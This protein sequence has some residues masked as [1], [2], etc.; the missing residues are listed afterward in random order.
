MRISPAPTAV[1]YGPTWKSSIPT[2]RSPLGS[3]DHDLGLGG[4][5]HGREVLGRIG[6]AE[7]AAD[8]AAVAHDRVGDHVLGIAEEREVL[9][10]QLGLEE[11]DMPRQRADPDLAALLADVRE[12]REIVDVD[13]VLGVRQPQLHHRQQAV[14]ARDDARLGTE[15]LEG[16][17]GALHTRRTLVLECRRSLQH[18]LL[19]EVRR[20]DD[21]GPLNCTTSLSLQIQ[22]R[23]VVRAACAGQPPARRS[24]VVALL[25]LDG[26]VGADHGRARQGRRALDWR[27]SGYSE[28]AARLPPST[29]L[30]TGPAGLAIAIGASRPSRASVSVPLV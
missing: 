16:R 5:A 1:M 13:Q 24:D 4:G 26:R 30:S 22:V 12:L 15:P 10:E 17:D 28:R 18:V 29:F 19:L 23:W 7:R 11:I 27:T 14:T 6:L 8:R 2:T 9:G 21:G 3:A 20:A 25:V